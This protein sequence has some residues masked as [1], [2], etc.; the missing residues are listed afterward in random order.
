MAGFNSQGHVVRLSIDL[1]D[2][3]LN[4]QGLLIGRDEKFCD[5]YIGDLSVSRQHAK[6]YKRDSK[7][8]LEDLGSTNG[9]FL[10][11]RQLNS[12]ESY[13]LT[14]EGILTFGDIELSIGEY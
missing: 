5:L 2:E 14:E 6:I 9:T 3:K 13:P 10:N 11:G 1:N 8:I 4:N 12:N 7:I